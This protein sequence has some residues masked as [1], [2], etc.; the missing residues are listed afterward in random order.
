M[1]SHYVGFHEEVL[2][3]VEIGRGAFGVVRKAVWRDKTVAVKV[4]NDSVGD[5]VAFQCEAELM[6]RLPVHSNIVQTFGLT[7]IDDR[8]ALVTEY[9]RQGA[10][11]DK[12]YGNESN[13]KW[14]EDSKLAIAVGVARGLHHLHKHNVIHRDVAARNVLLS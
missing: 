6:I 5:D 1:S 8:L 9:C 2:L 13:F 4:L 10:L 12:L 14:S 11:I 7:K 3:K